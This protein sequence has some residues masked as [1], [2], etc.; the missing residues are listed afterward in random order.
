MKKK[1]IALL[2]A[3]M[4]LTTIT[5]CN[6]DKNATKEAGKTEVSE[7]VVEKEA[8]SEA[9][10][11]RKADGPVFNIENTSAGYEGFQYLIEASVDAE[12]PLVIFM[13]KD[14]FSDKPWL[15]DIY[16][17]WGD[18]S[19]SSEFRLELNPS[20]VQPTLAESLR[21]L[22]EI[23]HVPRDPAECI[24]VEYTEPI[25]IGENIAYMTVSYLNWN[26][27]I[28]AY[29]TIYKTCYAE[30]LADGRNI[31]VTVKTNPLIATEENKAIIEELEAY[32]QFDIS[33]DAE[34]AQ[35]KMDAYIAKAGGN[36]RKAVENYTNRMTQDWHTFALPDGWGP[37]GN[38]FGYAPGNGEGTDKCELYF[39]YHLMEYGEE[40][41]IRQFLEDAKNEDSELSWFG[42]DE[43]PELY[44]M[45]GMESNL[46]PVTE[47]IVGE[48]GEGKETRIVY[49]AFHNDSVYTIDIVSPDGKYERDATKAAKILLETIEINE[50]YE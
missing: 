45:D 43:L 11:E 19:T 15:T 31:L 29:E 2:L 14:K 49:V 25:A 18:V 48:L 12:N 5:G 20:F 37:I 33:C 30:K 21:T 35:A 47:I 17:Y 42:Y 26:T 23:A 39:D 40:E 36:D 4:I 46:G 34:A 28:D 3:A 8:D 7:T 50:D 10:R 16:A 44:A 41:D 38:G 27:L 13:P 9:T 6:A 1:G 22:V 24:E 32:Y